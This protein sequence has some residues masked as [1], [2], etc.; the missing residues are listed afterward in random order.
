[1]KI[2]LRATIIG[3]CG[4]AVLALA[5]FVGGGQATAEG[6]ES[7]PAIWMQMTPVSN[8]IALT[9]GQETEDKFTIE[10][11][12]S[13]DFQYKVYA[14]PYSVTNENYDLSFSAE[15]NY[16]RITSW[17]TFRQGDGEWTKNPTFTIAKGQKQEIQYRVSVPQD[18]PAGGQY[19]TLFA[20][21]VNDD[22]SNGS[23]GIKTSSRVGL[24]LYAN[25]AGDSR[26]EGTIEDY[27]F[28]HFSL[29]G[30]ISATAKVKN[31]GNTDFALSDTFE[32]K[33]LFGKTV[34]PNTDGQT[35]TNNYS[36]LPDTERRVNHE[37]TKEE[38]APWIGVFQV[39]YKVSALGE[40]RDETAIVFV[41]PLVAIILL[42]LFLTI[43]TIW[44]IIAIRSRKERKARHEK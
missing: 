5:G 22:N 35:A 9:P 41:M 43:L 3:I 2:N 25:V 8:R 29:G 17:L 19:A 34:Y 23:T 7:Q 36:V 37:W 31:S 13:G 26:R 4:V 42:I 1:M 27:D 15:N 20:E 39:H 11:I 24:L 30:T 14:A 38:G 28:T 40:V 10:N 6:E 18:V 21:S 12:G 33:T 16:T 44:T 32:I